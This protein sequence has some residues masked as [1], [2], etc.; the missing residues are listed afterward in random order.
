MFTPKKGNRQKNKN[1]L[2]NFPISYPRQRSEALAGK[3]NQVCFGK[4]HLPELKTRV[5]VNLPFRA[6]KRQYLR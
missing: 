4:G 5:C 3:F 1:L 2:Y 6:H